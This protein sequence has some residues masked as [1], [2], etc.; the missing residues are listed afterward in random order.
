MALESERTPLMSHAS[1]MQECPNISQVHGAHGKCQ[2][3]FSNPFPGSAANSCL[4]DTQPH[5]GAEARLWICYLPTLYLIMLTV[6][7][8]AR[9]WTYL[10]PPAL[11]HN[12]DPRTH[13]APSVGP[14]EGLCAVERLTPICHKV[15]SDP[16]MEGLS[17]CGSRN[18]IGL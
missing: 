2:A 4:K 11:T 3:N 9:G 7:G 12:T 16:H 6:G 18:L 14:R 5:C 10:L 1:R 17:V 15:R 8:G 13:K